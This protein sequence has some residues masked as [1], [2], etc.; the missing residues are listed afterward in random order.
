MEKG[1]KRRKREWKR[2]V[3]GGVLTQM[4]WVGEIRHT[5]IDQTGE[6]N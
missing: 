3:R 5:Y 6:G 2:R 1:K 4:E